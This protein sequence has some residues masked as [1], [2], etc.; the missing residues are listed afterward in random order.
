MNRSLSFAFVFL[1]I[2]LFAVLYT[3]YTTTPAVRT[4]GTQQVLALPGVVGVEEPAM[5]GYEYQFASLAPSRQLPVGTS[6]ERPLRD[7]SGNLM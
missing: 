7:L 2:L 6:M 3:V 5:V 4:I 1:L